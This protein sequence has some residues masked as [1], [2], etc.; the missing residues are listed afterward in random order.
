MKVVV[1]GAY[2]FTGKL[3]CAQLSQE[4]IPF[5]VAG[6]NTEKLDMLQG[7]YKTVTTVITTDIT[8]KTGCSF[9]SDYDI[10]INCVGP[11]EV[12]A[13]QL[14]DQVIKQS[15]VYF[16]IT[17]EETFVANSIVHLHQT[18]QQNK[19]LIVHAV[20]FES[21]LASLVAYQ[22]I[23]RNNNV[24]SINSYYRFEQSKP[25][26]GTRFT[27]K[28]SKYRDT[29]FVIDGARIGLDQL[30]EEKRSI[31]IN[32]EVYF[33][34]PYP[35]P[36]IPFIQEEYGIPNIA[37]YLLTDEF[38]ASLAVAKNTDK[39]NLKAEIQKLSKRKPKGPTP[40]QRAAQYF[41]LVVETSS[42]K[43]E[44]DRI[45]LS[46][47]DMYLITAK[48]IAF[49]TKKQLANQPKKFGVC[50]PH[51]LLLDDAEEF[52]KYIGVERQ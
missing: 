35:M 34:M 28:L 45:R 14:L 17:G 18:A 49:F 9:V 31:Q 41:D 23:K 13:N 39:A 10:I 43:G 50:S 37:S 3:I 42:T 12:Y 15:K 52:L 5:A 7:E 36:E 32:D 46:G 8:Q 48:V 4:G 2:G 25:S 40:T 11:F 19:A 30:H 47:V 21:A 20:A 26:P 51:E 27:M 38:S 29:F 6:R 16:D 22:L 24:K 1:V 33:T 44:K